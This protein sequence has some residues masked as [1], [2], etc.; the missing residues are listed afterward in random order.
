[1]ERGS[2]KSSRGIVAVE[3]PAMKARV[4]YHQKEIHTNS[5]RFVN[6]NFILQK[7]WKPYEIK[8]KTP[9]DIYG[10]S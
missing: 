5:T 7:T 1:M 10:V 6:S 2:M 4:S 8:P 9:N 3:S